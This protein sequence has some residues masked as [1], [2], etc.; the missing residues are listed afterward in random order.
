[1]ARCLLLEKSNVKEFLD[2]FDTILTD[3]DGV[4]WEGA[5]DYPIPGVPE[6]IQQLKKMGKRVFYVSNNSTKTRAEYVV[7]CQK[8]QYDTTEEEVVGSA[9]ATAQY[10]KH[11][12][13]Y[14]GKVYIIGS[15]GI[16]GEFDAAGIP[17]FG[18]GED[19]WNGRGLRDLLDIKIDPEVKCVV[20]GF[21]LH[22]NYVKLFTAQQYLSDPEC[23]FIAT[24]TDSALPAG[25][26]GIL[27]GTG[28]I[29]SAVEFSTGRQATVCGKPH[30]PLG[31]ILVQQHGINPKRTIMI[32]DRL[33][34]DMALAHNCGMRGLLVL[35]GFTKLED[36]RRLTA[37]NSIAHQ[38]QIPHYYLP[39][40]VDLG[41]LITECGLV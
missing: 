35:T 2:S 41:K 29:V 32:G 7:K 12:L 27:P 3:C 38:K 20:V 8:L 23:L 24:N 17:H 28:A 11:T 1:M 6:T 10:V 19:G 37:S 5:A 13:G 21:D 16:A 34:T 15:S 40:L 31:D 4:L 14:K 39:S 22:F 36:A 30:N 33:D 25:G 26:G 18:V 9:Y